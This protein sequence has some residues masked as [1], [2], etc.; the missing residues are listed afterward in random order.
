MN[1]QRSRPSGS[2]VQRHRIVTALLVMMILAGGAA[3][4]LT[5]YEK[6]LAEYGSVE[7]WEPF[8]LHELGR[9]G[10][11]LGEE[12]RWED[13]LA[14]HRLN[15]RRHPDH[16]RVWWNLGRALQRTGDREGAIESYERA[17]AV[18]PFSNLANYQRERLEELRKD[19]S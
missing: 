9:V 19:D 3:A 15:T 11:D 1:M 7:W 14:A 17:L 2:F 12:D 5:D 8:S 18:D 13:A 4:A 10:R 16:W 6:R